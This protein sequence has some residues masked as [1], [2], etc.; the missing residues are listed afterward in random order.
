MIVGF[1]VI[2]YPNYKNNAYC[3][4]LEKI[5]AFNELNIEDNLILKIISTTTRKKYSNI[6]FNKPIRG[7]KDIYEYKYQIIIKKLKYWALKLQ[8]KED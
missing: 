3:I 7:L 6:I 1:A 4:A 8:K 5:K 2:L